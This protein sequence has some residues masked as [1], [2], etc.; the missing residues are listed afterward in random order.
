MSLLNVQIK[1]GEEIKKRKEAIQLAEFTPP[2]PYFEICP[3][4]FGWLYLAFG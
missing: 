3:G 2:T 4:Y 1:K